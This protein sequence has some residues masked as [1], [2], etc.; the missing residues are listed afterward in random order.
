MALI[1]V[2]PVVAASGLSTDSTVQ[3]TVHTGESVSVFSPYPSTF[4]KVSITGSS[5]NLLRQRVSFVPSGTTGGLSLVHSRLIG[6]E[7][8]FTPENASAYTLW[9]NVSSA[10]PTY[11]LISNGS[12]DGGSLL[13]NVT[14]AS[15]LRLEII[16]SVIPS[17]PQN[18][19]W[20]LLFGFT[21]LSLGGLNLTA[22]E[23]F[24]ALAF[25]AAAFIGI[26]MVSSKKLLWLGIT[27]AF[28]LAAAMAG[29][30]IVLLAVTLYI[31][32]FIIIR[33]YFFFR[34]KGATSREAASS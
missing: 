27:L 26:G 13:K 18:A 12:V 10:Q 29:V 25:L 16:V 20:N 3:L 22:P 14:S 30:L 1:L 23:A 5:Y 4:T 2:A 8:I 7:I 28:G 9:A 24:G 17:S 11:V 21:G 32:S 31:G 19:G 6:D 15:S 34:E 33:S